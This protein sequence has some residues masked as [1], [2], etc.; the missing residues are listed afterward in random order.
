LRIFKNKRFV[1]FARQESISNAQ[2]CEAVRRAEQGQIDA[3]LGSGVIKQ[4]IAR[5]GQG[6]SGGFRS[7]VLYKTAEK[8]FFVYGFAKSQKDNISAA[9]LKL[10][11]RAAEVTLSFE[12]DVLDQLITAG[13]LTEVDCNE[14]KTDL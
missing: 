14:E 6:K 3:D 4:R 9:D 7:I 10:F 11:K 1:R 2:L 12:D 5:P 8:A 13:E